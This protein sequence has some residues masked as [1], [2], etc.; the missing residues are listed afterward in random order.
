[1]RLNVTR[2]MYAFFSNLLIKFSL[3]NYFFIIHTVNKFLIQHDLTSSNSGM[4]TFPLTEL[5]YKCLSRSL[6]KTNKILK[7]VKILSDRGP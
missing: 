6:K 5:T 2:Q 3:F 4:E 1:M 7:E